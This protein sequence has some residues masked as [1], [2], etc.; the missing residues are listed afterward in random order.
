MNMVVVQD[1]LDAKV[2]AEELLTLE[3]QFRTSTRVLAEYGNTMFVVLV[4]D[5]LDAKVLAEELLA[6]ESQFRTSTMNP[7]GGTKMSGDWTVTIDGGSG[8]WG[9]LHTC[10]WLFNHSVKLVLS[11]YGGSGGVRYVKP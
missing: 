10:T 9:L 8:R 5:S 1:C 11:P 2:L 7:M 3:S 6:L 4:Q